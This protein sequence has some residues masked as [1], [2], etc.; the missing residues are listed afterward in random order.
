MTDDRIITLRFKAENSVDMELYRN[1]EKEKKEKGLSMPVYVKDV[2]RGHF[3]R[4]Q[5]EKD[6]AEMDMC[7]GRIQNIV[8]EELASL[9][10]VIVGTIVRMVGN[11]I[12]S[13]NAATCGRQPTE[14]KDILPEYSD[15]FPEGLDSVLDQ[16]M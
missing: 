16:F 10:A 13:T 2:L 5:R 6:D 11:P 4:R 9:S 14:G 8:R 1:L 12:D 15:E 3:E 7:M